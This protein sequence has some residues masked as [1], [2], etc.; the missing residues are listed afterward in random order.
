MFSENYGDFFSNDVHGPG[1]VEKS[2]ADWY[3]EW[4]NIGD[5]AFRSQIADEHVSLLG[6]IDQKILEH[7]GEAGKTVHSS[8]K[9][10]GKKRIEPAINLKNWIGWCWALIAR[11]IYDGITYT[12]CQNH[13][14]EVNLNGCDHE[15]PLITPAGKK[16]IK[17]C[18][19][20][21]KMAVGRRVSSHFYK[22]S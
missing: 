16:G 17:Y 12:R 11:D 22:K 13:R 6:L 18:S 9:R 2:F 19:N 5:A 8:T 1:Y 10:V 21:C 7:S 3:S 20:Y 4:E 14:S 15:V